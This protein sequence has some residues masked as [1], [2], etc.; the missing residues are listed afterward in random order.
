MAFSSFTFHFFLVSRICFLLADSAWSFFSSAGKFLLISANSW[1]FSTNAP[2]ATF[3][4][5]TMPAPELL[6]AA[7]SVNAWPEKRAY[8]LNVW[9][10]IF[11]VR[12]LTR[13][14]HF[15]AFGALPVFSW[16]RNKA[17]KTTL[18]GEAISRRYFSVS[19]RSITS[20]SFLW[21]TSVQ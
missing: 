2:W 7:A 3:T 14:G 19:Y 11:S 10:L 4:S 17:M 13:P 15:S 9:G 18:S 6:T 5:E 20:I 16:V 12:T 8:S 1:F 21:V